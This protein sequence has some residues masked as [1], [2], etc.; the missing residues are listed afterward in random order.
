[1]TLNPNWPVLK[2][3][4]TYSAEKEHKDL[5]SS[6]G[7]QLAAIAVSNKSKLYRAS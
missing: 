5:L 1:M 4:I 3:V 6:Y 7:V 2:E